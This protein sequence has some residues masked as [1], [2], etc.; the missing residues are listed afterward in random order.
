MGTSIS[1]YIRK[2]KFKSELLIKKLVF[3]FFCLGSAW[4]C[5]QMIM[6]FSRYAATNNIVDVVFTDRTE[7]QFSQTHVRIIIE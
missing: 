7:I 2:E 4:V 5:Q 3:V 1:L 6:I